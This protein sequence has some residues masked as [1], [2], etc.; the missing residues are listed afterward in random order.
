MRGRSTRRRAGAALA[1]TWSR[2]SGGLR[3][4]STYSLEPAA[5]M[6]RAP[7]GSAPTSGASTTPGRDGPA[8]VGERNADGAR[9]DAEPGL[10]ADP[11]REHSRAD[12]S[13]GV[14][15][16]PTRVA[17]T[18]EPAEDRD[19]AGL[20]VEKRPTGR[21]DPPGACVEGAVLRV[22]EDRNRLT[23]LRR[24]EG[25]RPRAQARHVENGD[26]VRPVDGERARRP[27][28]DLD[29]FR[30]G[31]DMGGGDDEMRLGNPAG[32]FDTEPARRRRH[33]D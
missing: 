30:A 8:R 11:R 28:V 10:G 23:W 33:L 26:V 2:R 14:D 5:R 4:S 18:H 9:R 16:G 13:V 6:N 21:A 19:V 7:C 32:P 27:A 3:R 31:H 1:H 20:A 22:A 12:D 17:V 24:R 25:E 29:P 15:D